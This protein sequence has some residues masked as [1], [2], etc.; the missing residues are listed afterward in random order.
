MPKIRDLA[1]FVVIRIVGPPSESVII[2]YGP[3]SFHQQEK[4]KKNLDFCSFVT[5]G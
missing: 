3:G 2:L 1:D 4:N 5:S